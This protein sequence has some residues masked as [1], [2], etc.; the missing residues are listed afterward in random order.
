MWGAGLWGADA[1]GYNQQQTAC[2]LSRG[3]SSPHLGSL[4]DGQL[5]GRGVGVA[6]L[7]QPAPVRGEGGNMVAG[8]HA[9]SAGHEMQQHVWATWARSAGRTGA[10]AG[11]QHTVAHSSVPRRSLLNGGAQRPQAAKL[12]DNPDALDP[13]PGL[14]QG[15]CPLLLLLIQVVH[16][17]L[18]LIIRRLLQQK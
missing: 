11:N 5:V 14:L 15:G 8:G 1:G 3:A 6:L 4:Q 13:L 12:L 10:H 17:L 2:A 9:H 7:L 18:P 16:V